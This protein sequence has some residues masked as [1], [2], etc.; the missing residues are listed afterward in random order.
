MLR[1]AGVDRSDLYLAWDF[2]VGSARSLAGRL[3]HIRN[4]AFDQLG[5]HDLGDGKVDG[6]APTFTLTRIVDSVR[7]VTDPFCQGGVPLGDIPSV[8]IKCDGQTNDNIALDVRGTMD[9]PCYLDTPACAPA[10]SQ[11]LLD[12]NGNPQQLAGNVMQVDFECRV[13]RSAYDHPGESRPS[14]YGHG[15]FG[16]YGEVRAGNVGA[17]GN[18]HNFTFCATDWAGMATSDVPNVATILTDVSSF[19]TLADRVQQGIVNFLYLGRLM[20][21]PHGLTD[22]PAFRTDDNRPLLDTGELYYDGNSQG[23]I[24]GGALTAVAPDFTRAVLGV[25]GMNYST[26]LTRSTDFGDGTAPD[27]ATADPTDPTGSVSYAYPLYTSYP[28]EMERPLLLALIQSLWDRAEPDGYAQHMTSDP[29]PKTP[30]H[31]VLLHPAFGDHQVANVAADTEARTI[32]ASAQQPALDPGR[33]KDVTPLW[34]IPPITDPAF[35][36]SAIVYWDSGVPAAPTNNTAPHGDHDPHGDPRSTRAA[37]AQKAAFL[38]PDGRVIDTCG[39][40]P[41]HTDAYQAP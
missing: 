36:G 32:G 23:G 1:R 41:C 15:L 20:I 38:A 4:D 34:G 31:T 19:P 6:N 37:R 17:M 2:T 27:P 3:L 21:H 29:Y 39:G 9:V 7:P 12:A 10:H 16:S 18:E 24:I 11:F 8:Q 25:P 35:G 5:D 22:T 14:L 40:A 28:N 33:S 26:L 30:A 13:P